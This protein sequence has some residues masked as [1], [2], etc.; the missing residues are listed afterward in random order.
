[1]TKFDLSRQR[2]DEL[3]AEYGRW[4]G[5]RDARLDA[6]GDRSFGGVGFHHEPGIQLLECR[7][8]IEKAYAPDDPER[9]RENFR[10]V[11]RTLADPTIGGMYERGGGQIV[12][13]EA[14]RAFFLIYEFGLLDVGVLAFRAKLEELI[15]IGA[16]WTLR[17]FSQVARVTHGR[18]PRPHKF[19]R[20]PVPDTTDP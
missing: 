10:A 11:A 3:V 5:I 13:D 4:L 17:W 15:D 20:R 19:T 14:K 9:I 7:V 18:A 16:H 2:A 12:L 1:M 8:F 6:A